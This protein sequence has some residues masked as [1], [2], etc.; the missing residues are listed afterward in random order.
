MRWQG[1][2]LSFYLEI[3]LYKEQKSLIYKKSLLRIGDNSKSSAR[4]QITAEKG[5]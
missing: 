5:K 3:N 1:T 2:E 4:L